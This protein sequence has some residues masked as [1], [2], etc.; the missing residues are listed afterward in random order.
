MTDTSTY[1]AMAIQL[2]ARSLERLPDTAAARAAMLEHIAEIEGGWSAVEKAL[3]TRTSMS[4]VG[5]MNKFQQYQMGNA[6]M[7]AA[8]AVRLPLS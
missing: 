4:V 7:A 8:S 5:D 2:T 6:M 1:S 3:D